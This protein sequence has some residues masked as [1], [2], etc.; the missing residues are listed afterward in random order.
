MTVQINPVQA[1]SGTPSPRNIRRITGFNGFTIHHLAGTDDDAY[2]IEFDNNIGTIYG[3]Q[4][5]ASTGTMIVDRVLIEKRCVDMN[6]IAV[7]PGWR[8]SG[9]KELIGSGISMLYTDQMLNVGTT[10]GVDTTGDNDLLYLGLD[11]YGMRQQDWINT[12]INVQICI[13][14]ASPIVYSIDPT[15][16]NV[17]LGQNTFTAGH[18]KV[19]YIKYPCDLKMYIDHKIA[20][21]QALILDH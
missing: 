7:Q 13:P 8:N 17:K 12:E 5:D 18:G 15:E 6:N 10:F 16:I 9:I 21:L 19:T 1:G 11:Q 20:E 14:L 4:Y 2:N 3:C